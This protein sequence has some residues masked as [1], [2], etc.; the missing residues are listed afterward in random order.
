MDNQQFIVRADEYFTVH[1]GKD[2][3]ELETWTEGGVNMIIILDDQERSFFEQFKKYVEEFDIDEQI[4][5]H[6]EDDKYRNAFTVRNSLN[7]F[8][9]FAEWLKTALT[10]LETVE[11]Q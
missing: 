11:K 3:I 8:E 9:D 4:D 1:E 10:S 2:D 5:L 6:R 7:D